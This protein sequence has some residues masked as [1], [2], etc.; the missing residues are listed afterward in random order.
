MT[1]V[2][3]CNTNRPGIWEW[4]RIANLSGQKTKEVGGENQLE[5]EDPKT[6]LMIRLTFPDSIWKAIIWKFIE[7]HRR[8]LYQSNCGVLI[9][10]LSGKPM[11]AHKLSK[12]TTILINNALE[13]AIINKT[14]NSTKFWNSTAKR[15]KSNDLQEVWRRSWLAAQQIYSTMTYYLFYEGEDT[16][17][18]SQIASK[19]IRSLNQW[20]SP[21]KWF[22]I[23]SQVSCTA[24]SS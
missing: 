5:A 8:V 19:E 12:S 2:A 7:C 18:Q 16:R 15:L 6:K 1:E 17:E 3:L 9:V 14:A 11:N 13:K 24:P 4:V 21:E 22:F 20:T 10:D 23:T